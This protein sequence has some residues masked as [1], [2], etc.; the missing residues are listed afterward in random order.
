[1]KKILLFASALAGLFLAASCQQENLEL[2]QQVNTVTYTVQVPGSIGTKAI[3]TNV[4]A[5]TELI[6]EVYRIDENDVETRLYQK[7]TS[8]TSGTATVEL[9]LVNNQDF[10]V[11]FWAQVPENGVYTTTSLKNVT[12]ATGLNANA[13]NYAAFAGQ[14]EITYGE[15]LAGRTVTLERPV[16]QLNIAT[17][18][19][20][21]KLGEDENGA[22]PQTT[23]SFK[24]TAVTVEG[25]SAVYNVADQSVSATTTTFVY[26][27]TLPYDND[28]TTTDNLSEAT[29]KVNNVDYQYVSMNYVGF[30][31]PSGDNVKVTYTIETNEVG[32]ITNTI[33]N[34]PVK[35]NHRTNIIGN[36]ITS[37]SDYTV[38][39][40]NNWPAEET[41][42]EVVSVST[43]AGLQKAINAI[44]GGVE[45]NITLTD[46]IDLSALASMISTKAG[47][48]TYG[49]IIPADKSLVLD[50]N[51]NT[52]AQTVSQTGA[53]SMIQNNGNLTIV[54][55]KGTG[56]IAYGD[57]GNGGNYVSNT[58]GNSGKLVIES[59]LIENNSSAAVAANGYPHPI[60]NSGELI[61]NGGTLT[62][63]ANYSSMRIW[64]TTDDDTSVTINGGTFNGSIDFQTV[65]GDPN[66][67]VLTINA[68]TFNPDTY[69]KS[70]VRLLGFG[71]DVDEM[72]GY[73][74]GGT[75][76]G[77]VKIKKYGAVQELNSQVFYISGGIFSDDPTE[78]LAIGY[79]TEQ[80][81]EGKW[82]IKECPVKIGDA[83]YYATLADAVAAVQEGETITI[84]AGKTLEEGTIKL[85]AT[86]KNVTFRGTEKAVLK[87]MTISAAD[88][89]AYS[90]QNL[91]FD[92]L[93]FDN[94]RILLT[95]WRNGE[96]V[97]ENL[98]VTNCT[99]QNL[100]D[101]TNSAPVH[102]NKEASEAVNGFTF[103]NNVIDGATGGQKSGVY[104][105]V[106]GNVVFTDNV[107][108]NVSFRPYVIQ[109]TTDDGIADSFVVTGNTFSGSKA[110]RAQ[111]LG[112]NAEGT[113]AVN[114]VI[115]E[116]IFKGI[117]DAQQICYWN[118]NPAKTTADLSHN[119]YDIDILAN[120][121]KIYYNSAAANV[122]DLLD[123][124]VFPIYTDEAKTTLYTPEV[125][126]AKIGET[127]YATLEEAVAAAKAGDTITVLCKVDYSE[128]LVLPENSSLE[129]KADAN[130]KALTATNGAT[131]IIEDGKTLTLN[132]FSFGS[133]DN[134]TAE[135]EIKGGTVTANYGFFQHGTY[136]LRSNFE[137]GYMYYSYG[138]N[139]T[140][141][142]TFH[143]QGLGDGL[144]YVRGNLTIANGGKS[145]HDKSLWVGQPASWGAM[146]ASLVIEEGGYVQANSLCVY[147]GSSLTYY[148]NADLKY[149]KNTFEGTITAPQ[150][151]NEIWYTATALVH[152]HYY[153]DKF[154]EGTDL[155]S[156][157][158]DETTGKGVITLSGPITK[159]SG[160]AFYD[161]DALISISFPNS[162]TT[163]GDNNNSVFSGCPNL[164]TVKFGSNVQFIGFQAFWG[165]AKLKNVVLPE[166]LTTIGE[167]AFNSCTA[168]KTITIP[169][170]VT[171]I[172]DFAF[173]GIKELKMY[174]NGATPPSVGSTPFDYY[175]T[176]IYVPASSLE[177]YRTAW[178][179]LLETTDYIKSM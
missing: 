103:T 97:I 166:S 150:Q 123:M 9:E 47:A 41:N 153:K 26:G 132:N 155:V 3:G 175:W 76:N 25:L 105:Q 42:V 8:L 138:S 178:G 152:A 177:N 113:D 52:L 27:A 139:I 143:S 80:D 112:N 14:D 11:L 4:D 5:V 120:P 16:A 61:I 162:V 110:G 160:N 111:G 85:P 77:S 170:G 36:L 24:T 83:A 69:T 141:Y 79:A 90:Y 121:G 48:P 107:I 126:S 122:Y 133:K 148:N 10:R 144:D 154:G 161:R 100:F 39:L 22:N 117:T 157:V 106:T 62:N 164:E 29:I 131:I 91:T 84:L 50:L 142:G 18:A 140:V 53:Y 87:D 109:V 66:K 145:I 174:C 101:T 129:I 169:A 20:S 146:N 128:K 45:G 135:Y 104:A 93:T 74:K 33:S 134:A 68:G 114:I 168:L 31:Q 49:L 67:G 81:A 136:E 46:N 32:T 34:V 159:I 57:T 65:N 172:G 137:T 179:H 173:N 56:K 156:N 63:N 167:S 82:I 116:N 98:T 55:S 60:D 94:S 118:F 75:F 71:A 96:E 58:I 30:A 99:F 151:D 23:V 165:C 73:I 176:E 38:T 40:D 163:I 15:N 149:N 130:I 115:S 19:E 72:F 147:E 35:A 88:G 7:K 44:P 2:E 102:I 43:A 13:E 64:C 70:S 17:S 21:L 54:D 86:L 119:Y 28:A 59:G 158:W 6:Y 171:S 92:G 127:E 125:N 37:T 95:G 51:G 1:M 124:G 78:F 108:N 12:L 89:N